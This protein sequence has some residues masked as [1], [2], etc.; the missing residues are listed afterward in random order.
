MDT[1][2][3]VEESVLMGLLAKILPEMVWLEIE[4]TSAATNLQWSSVVGFALKTTH[5]QTL[6]KA[7]NWG[8]AQV[9]MDEVDEMLEVD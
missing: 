1:L 6:E 2:D 7:L 4:R 5:W 8:D 3:E 9:A